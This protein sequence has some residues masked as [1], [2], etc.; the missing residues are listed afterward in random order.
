MTLDRKWREPGYQLKTQRADMPGGD[1]EQRTAERHVRV[2]T[3]SKTTIG[4][5]FA[6]LVIGKTFHNA[7]SIL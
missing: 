3:K 2:K 1:R 6:V 7:R 4:V 5:G